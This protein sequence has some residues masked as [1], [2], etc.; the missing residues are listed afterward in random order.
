MNQLTRERG[1]RPYNKLFILAVE[2]RVTEAQY[3]HGL[4]AYNDTIRIKI[5]PH[6]H[7][8]AP[9][10]LLAAMQ[11]HLGS[12]PLAGKDEAWIVAD[13]DQWPEKQLDALHAWSTEKENY[14]LAVSN[15]RFELWLLL[16]FEDG[17]NISSA[18]ACSERLKKH[19]PNYNKYIAMRKI[20]KQMIETA[21]K[22]AKAKDTPPCDRW[23]RTT[24]STV[25]RLVGTMLP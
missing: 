10:Q 3:F 5:V 16:H 22:H 15:P 23:P 7:K 1:N 19:L 17:H 6:K 13:R 24:G 14:H 25:Y 18:Q 11:T 4:N 12:H 20:S 8:S 2:G 9:K 21:I